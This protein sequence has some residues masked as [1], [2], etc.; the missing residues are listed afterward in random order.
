MRIHEVVGSY[1]RAGVRTTDATDGRLTVALRLP[2]GSA[3]AVADATEGV[4]AI[5]PESATA[6]A[7]DSALA[8]VAAGVTV[9]LFLPCT[10]D[11]LPVGPV[12]DSLTRAGLQVTEVAPI[13][14]SAYAT[15]VVATRSDGFA[16]VT[17]YLSGREPVALGE[18]ALRRIVGEH[19]VGGLALRAQLEL[20]TARAAAA[21]LLA[22]R[23]PE[24]EA[25]LAASRA[26]LD[27]V[28]HSRSYGW[29]RAL[30]DVRAKPISGVVHLP[31]KLR[32]AGKNAP[33]KAIEAPGPS[34]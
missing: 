27:A 23:V 16:P 24:L 17:S 29:G 18:D 4:V 2:D 30:A 34:S 8:G 21:E 14:Q 11:S 26:R 9:L 15:V 28:V 10:A 6:A 31:G 1:S 25:D 32:A 33:A 22:T 3:G 20:V 12:V 7:L 5:A 19:L 13:E